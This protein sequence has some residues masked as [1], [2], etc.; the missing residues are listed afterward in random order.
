MTE[1]ERWV[2]VVD[3]EE[4]IGLAFERVLGVS[5]LRTD[6]ALSGEEAVKLLDRKRYRALIADQRLGPP[7]EMEGLDVVRE[8]K[9]RY[10]NCKVV[11]I[12]AFEGEG[13]RERAFDLGAEAYLEKPVS[14]Q[15]VRELL[16]SL[17]V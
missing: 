2:L 3:D 17:G 7:G 11:M 15:K 12:T 9:L 4:A 14:P 13:T 8:A 10:P 1:Q 16:I 5:G 6:V